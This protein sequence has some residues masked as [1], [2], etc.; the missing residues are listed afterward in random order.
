MVSLDFPL[1]AYRGLR[2]RQKHFID[3]AGAVPSNLQKSCIGYHL[4]EAQLYIQNGME[5]ETKET[6]IH[7]PA[8]LSR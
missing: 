4:Y 6:N 7:W 3:N 8:K 5:I 1:A 2:L